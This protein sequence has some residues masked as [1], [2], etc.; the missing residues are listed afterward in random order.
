VNPDF[1]DAKSVLALPLVSSLLSTCLIPPMYIVFACNK[2]HVSEL[3][4]PENSR[5]IY[6]YSSGSIRSTLVIRLRQIDPAH[7]VYSQILR[8]K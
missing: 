2:N 8:M 5:P 1:G 3:I 6:Q 7:K 4:Q